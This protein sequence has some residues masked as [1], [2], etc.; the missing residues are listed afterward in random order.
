MSRNTKLW[1]T[2]VGL[3]LMWLWVGDLAAS[4][5]FLAASFVIIGQGE[6]K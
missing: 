4:S 6:K 3:A 5:A 1:A 2:C